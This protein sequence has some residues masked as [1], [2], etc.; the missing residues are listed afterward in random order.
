MMPHYNLSYVSTSLCQLHHTTHT[1]DILAF[2]NTKRTDDKDVA[3][4]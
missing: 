1:R 3:D 2:K 4:R